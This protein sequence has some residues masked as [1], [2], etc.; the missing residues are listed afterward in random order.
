ML[1]NKLFN[2]LFFVLLLTV[3]L[4]DIALAVNIDHNHDSNKSL[5]LSNI[6]KNRNIKRF[7]ESLSN[8]QSARFNE[9]MVQ[10][11]D[12]IVKTLKESELIWQK[13]EHLIEK[14]RN[15]DFGDDNIDIVIPFLGTDLRYVKKYINNFSVRKYVNRIKGISRKD[16]AEFIKL[17]EELKRCFKRRFASVSKLLNSVPELR[18]AY[19]QIVKKDIIIFLNSKSKYTFSCLCK[20]DDFI[21]CRYACQDKNCDICKELVQDGDHLKGLTPYICQDENCDICQDLIQNN[22]INNDINTYFDNSDTYICKDDNCSICIDN[23]NICRDNCSGCKDLCRDDNCSICIDNC[24]I[25][26]KR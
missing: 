19:K 12:I 18:A 1:F 8:K 21:E 25:C 20:D 2:R 13:H 16:K 11:S 5:D 9:F 23:C 10:L 17:G 26:K 3:S 6:M 15:I 4:G 14:V 22:Y 7:Y 24:S